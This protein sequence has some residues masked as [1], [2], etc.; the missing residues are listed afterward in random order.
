VAVRQ[1]R[2]NRLAVLNAELDGLQKE[3]GAAALKAEGLKTR[4][5][6][7]AE[8][9]CHGTD[10]QPR[11]KLLADANEARTLV[12]SADA[13]IDRIKL[14]FDN[15][16]VRIRALEQEIT[17]FGDTPALVAEKEEELQT[18]LAERRAAEKLAAFATNLADAEQRMQSLRQELAAVET[19]CAENRKKIEAE[20]REIDTAIAEL[21]IRARDQENDGKRM[22]ARLQQRIDSLPPAFDATRID[23]AEVAMK[24]AE[25]RDTSAE[26]AYISAVTTRA[27][28]QASIATRG[29]EVEKGRGLREPARQGIEQRWGDRAMHRR[30]W[31]HIVLASERSAIA[32]LQPAFCGVDPDTAGDGKKGPQ[33]RF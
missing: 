2:A 22:A 15:T 7:S 18:V 16:R 24:A 6:L 19:G 21:T 3:A 28:V 13:E 10:L 17:S 29:K 14:R 8:V 26:K 30:C 9:P 4:C 25:G 27:A 32:L 20:I 33:G 31:A 23:R 12:P 11:C 1:E 5:G